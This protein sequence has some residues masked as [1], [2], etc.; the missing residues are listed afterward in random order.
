MSDTSTS[1][2][3]TSA[4]PIVG[5]ILGLFGSLFGAHEQSKAATQAAQIQADAA[6]KAAQ[7]QD[8]AN[9]RA[10]VF[11]R[12]QA[13]NTYL[14]DESTRKAN[15]DQWSVGQALHN[16][17]RAKLGYGASDIPAYVPGVDPRFTDPGT[18][19]P[20]AAAGPGTP[21]QPGTPGYSGA[22]PT[23]A[24]SG[25][26]ATNPNTGFVPPVP[27]AAPAPG[28]APASVGAYLVGGPNDPNATR[29]ANAPI[30]AY[31]ANRYAPASV[32]S[33]LR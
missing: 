17:V 4:I 23:N 29:V 6:T 3:W 11:Q 21:I 7:L 9:Q 5:P 2:G 1:S 22:G 10:E 20:P 18:S 26:L 24:P 27:P 15:Y 8:A 33:Y 30:V 16:S 31:Q 25:P 19:A 12:Q 28:A 13:E 14:N 32:G